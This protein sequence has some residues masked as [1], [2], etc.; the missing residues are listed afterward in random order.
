MLLSDTCVSLSQHRLRGADK[1][2][3]HCTLHCLQKDTPFLLGG[4]PVS[5]PVGTSEMTT[6]LGFPLCQ[7][8]VTFPFCFSNTINSLDGHFLPPAS[9]LVGSYD[10]EVTALE[11]SLLDPATLGFVLVVLGVFLCMLRLVLSLTP[12]E[13]MASK[14]SSSPLASLSEGF[15]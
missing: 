5:L 6:L 15:S 13:E 10:V 12:T 7:R 2:Q 3:K 9:E 11:L 14:P 8:V 1:G 4:G